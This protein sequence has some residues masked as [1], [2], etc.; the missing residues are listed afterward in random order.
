LRSQL[1]GPLRRI[2]IEHGDEFHWPS[3][4]GTYF[5]KENGGIF[6]NMGIHYLDILED[7]G[8]ALTPVAYRDDMGGGVEANA[9]FELCTR[10]GVSVRLALSY[11]HALKNTITLQGEH[12]T[13][14]A[15]VNNFE[16][17]SWECRRTALTSRLQ[18]LRP[19]RALNGP[20][21]FISA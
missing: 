20:L 10:E 14:H 6:V 7:W 1:L 13:I 11:T 15:N 18:P 16:A 19:F 21:D 4:S 9:E 17:C 2:E 3:D 5:R 8:G 12:G